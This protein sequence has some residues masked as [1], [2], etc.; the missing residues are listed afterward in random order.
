MSSDSDCR[1]WT[2]GGGTPPRPAAEETEQVG[3]EREFGARTS[4]REARA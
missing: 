4:R 2:H 1:R 3:P